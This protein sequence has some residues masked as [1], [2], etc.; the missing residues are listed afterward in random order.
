MASVGAS[1]W[2]LKFGI[3]HGDLDWFGVLF[4]SGAARLML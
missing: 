4:C 3:S 1:T 2:E